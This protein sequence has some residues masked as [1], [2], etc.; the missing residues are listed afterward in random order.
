MK[1]VGV[2]ELKQRTSEVLREVRESREPIAITLRGKVVA[3]LV[4][5]EDR[6]EIRARMERTLAE[7]DKLA[8]EIGKVWRKGVSAVDAVREQ[9]RDL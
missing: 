2:R 7:M 5:A 4:P 1:H 6:D 8:E 3:Q 9:R